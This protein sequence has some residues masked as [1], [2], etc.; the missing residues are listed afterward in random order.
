MP[1]SKLGAVQELKYSSLTAEVRR[2]QIF[3]G[4]Y[5]KKYAGETSVL[6]YLLVSAAQTL[7][8]VPL[9]TDL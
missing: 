4:L 8:L 9:C 5:A 3:R 7:F 1:G 2:K 6:P